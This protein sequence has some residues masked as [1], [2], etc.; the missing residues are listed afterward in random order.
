M[1]SIARHSET[2]EPMVVY[3]ALYGNGGIWVR[4]ADMWNE[5]VKRDGEEIR[6]FQPL[7]RVERVSFYEMIFDEVRSMPREAA[8]IGEEI[9]MKVRLLDEY[10]TSGEW[11]EDYEA[12]EGGLLPADLKRGVLSQD[13]LYDFLMEWQAE[14]GK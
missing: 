6:R 5:T 1:L 14:D 3:Q 9:R 4:P 12:D 7:S 13:G 8:A 10:Y 11:Q 2:T